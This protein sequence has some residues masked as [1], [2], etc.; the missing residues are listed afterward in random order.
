MTDTSFESR[1]ARPAYGLPPFAV[2][3]SRDEASTLLVEVRGELDIATAPT[4]KKHLE[5]YNDASTDG[6]PPSIVYLL[7][8]LDF[9]DSSGLQTL[10]TAIDG[11]SVETITVREPSTPVRRLLELVGMGSMIEGAG[12]NNDQ[13]L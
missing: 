7:P 3:V 5:P 12:R 4:L 11:L 6:R 13:G 1:A 2:S 8:K 10:L 9:I